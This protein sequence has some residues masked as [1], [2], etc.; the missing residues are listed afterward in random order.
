MVARLIISFF[1]FLLLVTTSFV[2]CGQILNNH[3][4]KFD[5]SRITIIKFNKNSSYP[6][7][8]TYK[9]APLTQ[10]ELKII[11]SLLI[12]CIANHNNSL[13]KEDKEQWSIDL[14]KDDYKK[15]LVAITNKKGQKEVWVNCLCKVFSDRWKTRIPIVSDG[16]S[17]YFNFK[18][19]LTTKK[20]YDFAVNGIG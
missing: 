9:S 14:T 1:S 7:P 12:V 3:N 8:N 2:T 10:K 11:D 13:A 4:P 19:N 15:Q 18:I 5:S 17:C 6:F 20:Y 16:G